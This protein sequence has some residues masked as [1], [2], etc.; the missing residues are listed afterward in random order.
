MVPKCEVVRDIQDGACEI[1]T[2]TE[3][4]FQIRR[5]EPR[6]ERMFPL[7]NTVPKGLPFCTR[8][9]ILMMMNIGAE[10]M[11]IGIIE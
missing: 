8:R 4:V 1:H 10:I 2:R 7:L 11:S 3:R 5:H 6:K 9:V